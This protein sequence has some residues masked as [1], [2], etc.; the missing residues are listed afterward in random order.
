MKTARVLISVVSLCASTASA[1]L[2]RTA[3]SVHGLDTNPCS[4]ASPCRSFAAALSQTTS[5]GEVVAVDSAGYGPMSIAQPVTVEAAP[6]AYAGISVPDGVD[7]VYINATGS[8]TVRGLTI[9]GGA[10]P[11]YGFEING[12]AVL[13][14]Q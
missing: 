7:G 9:T 10:S 3:V 2:S 1:T 4:V 8:V 13:H 14:I 11:N 6:G 5:G 12:A